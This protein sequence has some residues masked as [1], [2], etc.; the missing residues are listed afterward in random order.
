MEGRISKIEAQDQPGNRVL[1]HLVDKK[2][3]AQCS[4][5]E[6]TI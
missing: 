2:S 1:S 5:F 6:L 4:Y 3:P